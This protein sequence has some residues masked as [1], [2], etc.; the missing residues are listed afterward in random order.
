MESTHKVVARFDVAEEARQAM[1]DLERKGIDAD[2]IHLAA[3]GAAISKQEVQETDLDTLRRL[4][5]RTALG[6]AAGAV[7]GAAIV[8]LALLVIRVESL[9]TAM[10][11]G[12][13]GGAMGGALIGAY[14]GMVVRL[15]VN[16]EAYDTAVTG[17]QSAPEVVLEVRLDDPLK[18]V[19]AV[20]VLRHHHAHQIDREVA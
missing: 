2:A 10:L 16:E 1:V 8:I 4:E 18:E 14:W 11:V 7:T 19:D 13:V 17:T 20:K 5:G 9:G 3:P 12:G 15:P 6:A